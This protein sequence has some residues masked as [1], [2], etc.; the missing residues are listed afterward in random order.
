MGNEEEGRG[1]GEVLPGIAVIEVGR[2]SRGGCLAFAP[3]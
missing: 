3:A 1:Y 2:K